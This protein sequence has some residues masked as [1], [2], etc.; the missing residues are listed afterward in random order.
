MSLLVSIAG[1]VIY[2][3]VNKGNEWLNGQLA[4]FSVSFSIGNL[5][6]SPENYFTA[7]VN[8]M[9]LLNS[10]MVLAI[11]IFNMIFKPFQ[12]RVIKKVDEINVSPSDFTVMVLNLPK[13]K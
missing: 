13:S 2:S 5:G 1:W 6:K 11:Y 7:N 10:L 3:R 4:P 9:I 8:I 12:I